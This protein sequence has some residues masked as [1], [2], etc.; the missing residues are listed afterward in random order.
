MKLKSIHNITVLGLVVLTL[1]LPGISKA[2]SDFSQIY[3]F[4]DSLSDPGNVYALTGLIAIPPYELIPSAPYAI[5]GHQ[6]SNGKTWAQIFAQNMKLGHGGRAALKAPGTNGN[7]AFGGA[8]ARDTSSPIPSASTQVGI[9]SGIYSS[10]DPEA[11]YV[12]QFGGNDLRDALDAFPADPTGV[13]S[14][15]I[16]MDA[17]LSISD[18]IISLYSMGARNFLVA[19]VPNLART[20]AVVGSGPGAVYLANLF[21]PSYND[22]LETALKS[23]ESALPGISINRI[24]FFGLINA[25]ADTPDDFGVSITDSPCLSFGVQGGANCTNPREY[26]FWD[27]IHPTAVIHNTIG[28][29]ATD[30]FNND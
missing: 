19:N 20:P 3:F 5:G 8:R 11:L 29:I 1:S 27:G 15:G 28:D 23:L 30:L 4:G 18:N 26:L 13:T 17:V 22:G 6:F 25:A 16:L 7:F 14:G 9:F 10:A 24:D 21:G 12:I 2:E